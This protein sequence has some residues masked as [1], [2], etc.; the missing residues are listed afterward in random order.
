M[1]EMRKG[2]QV[3]LVKKVDRDLGCTFDPKGLDDLIP[4]CAP[5]PVSIILNPNIDTD[6]F[7]LQLIS[8]LLLL[9]EHRKIQ[10]PIDKLIR[11]LNNKRV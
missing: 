6:R 11:C 3:L 8:Q 5:P 2:S 7:D 9:D 1:H 10:Q 4:A